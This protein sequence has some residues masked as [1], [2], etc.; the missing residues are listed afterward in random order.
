MSSE[1]IRDIEQLLGEARHL[2]RQRDQEL[3]SVN[4]ELIETN[5]GIV[6]LY[7]ELD[8]KAQRLEDAEQMLRARNEDLKAFAHT[9]AH[10]LKAPLRGIS[11]YA[12]ELERKHQANL[13]ERALFCLNQ[14]LVATHHLDRLI[15]DLLLVARLDTAAISC[16]ELNLHHLVDA[17][18]QDRSLIIKEQGVAVTV[19]I[20]FM[21]MVSW[22]SGLLRV[23]ANLI[24]N[25]LKFSRNAHPP[26]IAIRAE[27]T[28]TGWLLEVSDNGVGFDMKYSERIFGL[29]TR[30]V[31]AEDFEGTGAGLAIVR[32]VLDKLGGSIRAESQLGH[33]AAFIV[34]L[35]ALPKP[36]PKPTNHELPSQ[37]A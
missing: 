21:T 12:D 32:K 31:R 7:T 3:A 16:A 22:E 13:S 35:P 9:V 34:D 30:L 6:A 11:G 26:H 8:E 10:D 4:R 5:T 24:D 27:E 20:P 15:D 28:A 29:F 14:I 19:D 25:A 33:G 18:L 36:R 2:L 23:L 17:I 37:K 1:A